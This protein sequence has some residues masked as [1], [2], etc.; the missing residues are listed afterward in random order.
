MDT[1]NPSNFWEPRSDPSATDPNTAFPLEGRDIL[2]IPQAELILAAETAP[3]IHALDRNRVSR[4]TRGLVIK[5]HTYTLPSE[6]NAM[7]LVAEKTSIRVPKVHRSF[8][9]QSYGLFQS[10]GYIVM[11]YIDGLSLD[12]CWET[13]PQSTRDDIIHQVADMIA[14][15]Q[16]VQLP[17]PG[18]LGGG[19]SQGKWFTP[20]GA[21]PFTG[22]LDLEKYFNERLQIAKNF[23]RVSKSIPPFNLETSIFV[24]THLDIAPRNLVLDSD[25]KVWLI[26]WANSGAYPPMLEIATLVADQEKCKSFYETLLQKVRRDED[27]I[28]QFMSGNSVKDVAALHHIDRIETWATTRSNPPPI[29]P[30]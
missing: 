29:D 16:S 5:S 3:T 28:E 8:F 22:P 27:A 15:L 19:P 26:D 24:L 13:L 17:T 10:L 11:D 7:E 18:P 6:V 9:V 4:I 21:G 1:T 14:Q 23:S 2:S 12:K 30:D 25:G 20:Y